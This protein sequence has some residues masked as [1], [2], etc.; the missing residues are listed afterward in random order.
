MS[1]F[2]FTGPDHEN[3]VLLSNQLS[4]E[5]KIELPVDRT[6]PRMVPGWCFLLTPDKPT[7]SGGV[8]GKMTV[9]VAAGDW[10]C[11]I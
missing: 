9:E 11:H 5:F 1:S 2:V 7:V 6:I 10:L 8:G 4:N 3:Q